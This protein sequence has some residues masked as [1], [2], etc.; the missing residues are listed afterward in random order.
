MLAVPRADW[1]SMAAAAFE[2]RFV[3]EDGSGWWCLGDPQHL[4]RG[5]ESIDADP[6]LAAPE[7]RH[8]Y[9]TLSGPWTRRLETWCRTY[10]RA[11]KEPGAGIRSL[12]HDIEDWAPA[13]GA[14]GRE[15]GNPGRK[16]YGAEAGG[17]WPVSLA[18][19]VARL[20]RRAKQQRR[21]GPTAKAKTR[22]FNTRCWGEGDQW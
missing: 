13:D 16:A 18:F 5:V 6:E 17:G 7:H 14:P 15:P 2:D 11:V 21:T 20:G 4:E 10:D 1:P 12:V 3:S 9:V 8:R 22:R 19:F